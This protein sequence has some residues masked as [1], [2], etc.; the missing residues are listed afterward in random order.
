MVLKNSEFCGIIIIMI[1][2]D[3]AASCKPHKQAV[4]VFNSVTAEHFSNPSALH[5]GGIEAEKVITAAKETI[6]ER[7]PRGGDLI[8]T[9]GATESNNLAIFNAVLARKKNNIVIT[10]VEHP[11]VRNAAEHF[12]A[13]RGY[14]LKRIVPRGEVTEQAVIDAVDKHTAL[15]SVISVCGETGIVFDTNCIYE[16][17][18]GR[19]PDCIV[20]VDS[21]QSF[22]RLTGEDLPNAD[23]ISISAH[24]IG[25]IAGVGG[26]YVKDKIRLTPMLHGGG[27]QGG[28]RSGTLPTALI[29][30]F[31]KAVEVS[32]EYCDYIDLY[33]RLNDGLHR[34]GLRTNHRHYT[35][36][37][38]IVNFSCGVKS[39]VMLHYLAEN[40]VCVSSGSACARGKKSEVLAAYGVA[41]CNID[42]AIRV[43]FGHHNTVEEA[44]TFLNILE[45]GVKKWK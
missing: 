10:A 40:G 26:L 9:S 30:A 17:V 34:L 12:A 25:G 43:S 18:K 29:A 14:E 4:E 24:K 2:F 42:T 13:T 44:D 35:H 23:L 15:V 33:K 5:K 31:G 1:Y 27:Q 37:S 6:L 38:H 11:S 20:H 32:S 7:L 8:F 3:N 28:R 41:D 19:Y 45:S 39:E 16:E 36:L 21:V 22:T